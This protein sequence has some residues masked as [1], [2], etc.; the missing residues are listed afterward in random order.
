M[1][2]VMIEAPHSLHSHA[3]LSSC[4]YTVFQHLLLRLQVIRMQ[5]LIDI[6]SGREVKLAVGENH[7]DSHLG[8]AAC[9]D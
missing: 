8:D 1:L 9:Y 7:L 6:C 2:V 4:I 3:N 5:P